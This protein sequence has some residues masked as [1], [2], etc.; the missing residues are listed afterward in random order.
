[1]QEKL[2]KADEIEDMD[3]LKFSEVFA[4][5]ADR[6][7]R[8]AVKKIEERRVSIVLSQEELTRAK[9]RADGKT[10]SGTPESIRFGRSEIGAE[11]SVGEVV[12]VVRVESCGEEI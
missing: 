12:E 1:I 4:K 3:I 6:I 7:G 11:G 2:D 9:E 10:F 5:F 8:G